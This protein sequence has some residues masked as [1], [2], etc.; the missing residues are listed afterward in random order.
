[1]GY[2]GRGS[3]GGKSR[4]WDGAKWVETASGI[5]IPHNTTHSPVA[6]YQLDEL[7]TDTSGNAVTTLILAAGTARY[8]NIVP[9]IKGAAFDGTAY[10]YVNAAVSTGLSAPTGGSSD[11]LYIGSN[12]DALQDFNGA[13]SSVKIIGSALTPAQI[14]AEYN[15][16]LGPALGELS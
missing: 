11:K 12:A 8:T 5:A 10:Y 13:I 1:M 2:G 7:L 9:G 16:T 14:R 3:V 6:L 15:R 4:I